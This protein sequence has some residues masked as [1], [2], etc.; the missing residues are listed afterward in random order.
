MVLIIADTRRFY[1]KSCIK[2][3]LFWDIIRMVLTELRKYL[4]K[5]GLL[6]YI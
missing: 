3:G 5:W 1:D 2:R 4:E 6:R